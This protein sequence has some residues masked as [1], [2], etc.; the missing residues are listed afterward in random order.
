MAKN[1][2]TAVTDKETEFDILSSTQQDGSQ[3]QLG[4]YLEKQ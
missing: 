2:L 4:F 1:S 3:T